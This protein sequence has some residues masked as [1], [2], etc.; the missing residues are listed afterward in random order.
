MADYGNFCQMLV[1]GDSEAADHQ[2]PILELMTRNHRQFLVGSN[3]GG[4]RSN[5]GVGFGLGFASTIGRRHRNHW[6]G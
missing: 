3:G 2:A 5:E 1:K 4:D 6:R